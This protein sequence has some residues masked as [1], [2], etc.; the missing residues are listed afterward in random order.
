[1]TADTRRSPYARWRSLSL[2][3]VSI[4]GGF[5]AE[6]Q[7]T[8]Q[9]VSLAHGFKMLEEAGNLH[10]P[11]L[12]DPVLRLGAPRPGRYASLASGGPNT[13]LTC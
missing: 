6:R 1:M 9:S 8:N 12:A 13:C 10:S 5:R 7:R 4:T 11:R 3:N 2:D